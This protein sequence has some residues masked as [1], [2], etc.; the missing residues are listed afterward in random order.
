MNKTEKNDLKGWS[1]AIEKS[2]E[3]KKIQDKKFN[4]SLP[5]P[6]ARFNGY[7]YWK[8][9]EGVIRLTQLSDG[10]Y[11]RHSQLFFTDNEISAI[12][13]ASAKRLIKRRQKND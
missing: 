11:D 13:L 8:T 2:G 9:Y 4:D 6:H 7:G 5:I 10:S 12:N 3:L 1:E